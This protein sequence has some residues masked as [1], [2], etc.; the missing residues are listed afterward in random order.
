MA[1]KIQVIDINQNNYSQLPICGIKDTEHEGRIQKINWL[2]TYFKKGCKA[3]LLLT[4]KNMQIG[5]IEYLPGQY[6]WRGVDADGYMFIHCIYTHLK[7]YQRKG[8]GG[9]LIKAC[10]DDAKKEKT[11]GV[12]VLTRQKPW[13]ANS[14]IFLKH[15][16]KVIDTTPP[17]YELLVKKFNKSA[18]NPKFKD[19]WDKKLKKY[20]KGLTIII[21]NQCPHTIR[22]ANKIVDMARKKYK[23]KP[24]IVHI[25]TF[26]QAQNAPTP[27]AAF[28][29]IYNG[30]LLTDHQ[31]SAARFRNIM[32]KILNVL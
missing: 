9:L 20:D 12:A 5:Y 25:K 24:Q 31:I 10:I 11:K 1:E 13:L 22:H 28:T 26:R 3:K 16:F 29:I 14:Q 30:Q 18:P 7:K 2:K 6:A 23:L 32:N 8:Y 27:Y 15:G 17:D 21:A 4:E 19:N